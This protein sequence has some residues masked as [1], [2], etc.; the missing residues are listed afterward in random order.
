MSGQPEHSGKA[1]LILLD[2]ELRRLTRR[3]DRQRGEMKQST[4]AW[5]R[6]SATIDK[7]LNI[8]GRI[9]TAR[10]RDVAGLATKFR[11]ILWRIR[12]DEEVIMDEAVRRA[13]HRFG[14]QL[15]HMASDCRHT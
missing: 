6:W 13:L 5:Q 2:T 7:G 3:A 14:R 11:A 9:E 10:A 15:V 8:V 4:A 12:V 1:N